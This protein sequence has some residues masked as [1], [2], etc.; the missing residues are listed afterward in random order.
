M[1][2]NPY[3]RFQEGTTN[4]AYIQWHSSNGFQLVNQES[5]EYIQIQSGNFGLK[6]V[7]DGTARN[8]MHSGNVSTYALP[9]SGGTLTG[10]LTTAD[11]IVGNGSGQSRLFL[12]KADNNVSDH[13]IFYNGTTRVGEIG[14]EDGSWLRLNQETSTNIFTPRLFRSDGGFQ[15]GSG[16]D[17][18]FTNGSSWSGN[19]TKIQHHS[20]YLYIVGGANG[21]ILEREV[22]VDGI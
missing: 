19:H 11:L 20:N 9:I 3:I 22:Q 16:T 12:Q 17:I 10:Q 18:Q 13:I 8:V 6:F 1:L 7:V 15:V 5:G 4:K 2:L 14:V 21:I